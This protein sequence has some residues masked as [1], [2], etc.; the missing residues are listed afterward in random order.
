MDKGTGKMSRT[1]R[2]LA[3]TL[4]PPEIKATDL[5]TVSKAMDDAQSALS[6]KNFTPTADQITNLKTWFATDANRKPSID[7]MTKFIN[8]SKNLGS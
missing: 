3:K 1:L 8:V 5:E 6:S 7:N 4:I 2:K